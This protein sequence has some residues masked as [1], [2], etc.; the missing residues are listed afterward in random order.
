VSRKIVAPVTAI[1]YEGIKENY[2]EWNTTH[3]QKYVQN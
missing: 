1:R 2:I 3:G